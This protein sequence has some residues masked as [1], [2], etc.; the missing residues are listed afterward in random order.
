[1]TD[2]HHRLRSQFTAL[3]PRLADPSTPPGK[4]LAQQFRDQLPGVEWVASKYD[5]VGRIAS[6]LEMEV[7]DLLLKFWEKSDEITS[8]LAR[9]AARPRERIDVGLAEH[10][11]VSM[12]HPS[13]DI[14]IG[15]EP[16]VV[17]YPIEF[18]LALTFTLQDI[19]LML[20]NGHITG[21]YAG[22]C[23]V[24]G[25]LKLG[26]LELA[27]APA[28]GAEPLSFRGVTFAGTP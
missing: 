1:M 15:V 9:S 22:S 11:I 27:K 26:E 8:A 6:L 4:T 12:L 17:T 5:L 7:P 21:L 13:L 16:N 19:G 2:T 28:E 23:E 3:D 14:S 20:E 25:V 24:E 18:T 10:T